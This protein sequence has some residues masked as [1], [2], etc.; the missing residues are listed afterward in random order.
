MKLLDLSCTK[1]REY[2]KLKVNELESESKTKSIRDLYRGIIEFKKG[3][4]SRNNIV[5]D[6]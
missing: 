4:Q 1:C 6:N 5:K 3:S 2:L